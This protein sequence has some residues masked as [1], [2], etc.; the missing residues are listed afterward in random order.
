MPSEL[1]REEKIRPQYWGI[2]AMMTCEKSLSAVSRAIMNSIILKII[3]NKTSQREEISSMPFFDI[4]KE[5]ETIYL[6]RNHKH[7]I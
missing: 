2:F 6:I 5:R 7:D 3:L 4:P 1:K